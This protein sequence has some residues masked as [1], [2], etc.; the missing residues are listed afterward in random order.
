FLAEV[1]HSKRAVRAEFAFIRQERETIQLELT[2]IL[3]QVFGAQ[4]GRINLALR[5]VTEQKRAEEALRQAH[6]EM[7]Q[8]V[9][10]RTAELTE[11]LDRV[12]DLYHNA[13]CGYHSLDSHGVFIE[14][15]DTALKLLGY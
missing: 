1:C 14:I 13:P 9:L 11:T 4:S 12:N 5:D 10:E 6:A 2:G 7:E 3:I 8:R 15:N